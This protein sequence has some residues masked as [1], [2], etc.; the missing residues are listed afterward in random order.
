MIEKYIFSLQYYLFNYNQEVK[1]RLLA[2]F[3]NPIFVTVK[4]N[5]ILEENNEFSI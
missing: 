5:L 3:E 2:L 1:V 4:I